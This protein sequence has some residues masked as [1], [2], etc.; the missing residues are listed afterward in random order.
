MLDS[1]PFRPAASKRRRAYHEGGD[2][3]LMR[4]DSWQ[5]E[6]MVVSGIELLYGPA[7]KKR[8]QCRASLQEQI[9][10]RSLALA[11]LLFQ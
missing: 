5:R 4:I 3:S 9:V 8:P 2:V 11:V 1:F 6:R 10:T 7:I